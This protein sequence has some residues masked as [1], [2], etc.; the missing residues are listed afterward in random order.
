MM[1]A[2]WARESPV[3]LFDVPAPGMMHAE[4]GAHLKDAG[5]GERQGA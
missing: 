1:V 3:G 2:A 5:P 4:Y